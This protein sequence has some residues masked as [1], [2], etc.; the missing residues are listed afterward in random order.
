MLKKLFTKQLEQNGFPRPGE[1]AGMAKINLI[2][3]KKNYVSQ[4]ERL[5]SRCGKLFNINMYDEQCVDECNYHAKGI[6][7]FNNFTESLYRC[8]QNSMNSPGCSYANYHVTDNTQNN[9][10]KGYVTTMD[11]DPSY[12]YKKND[13]YALDCEMCYTTEGIE[14]TRITVVDINGDI[15]YDS[16][17]KPDNKIIDYNTV[18]SGITESMLSNVTCK[19]INVQAVLLSMIHSKSILVGHSLESDLK[20]LKII[21]SSVVDTSILFPHRMGPPKK[22]ALKTLCI[23]FLKLIIQES[24]HG[25]N[26]AEDAAVCIKLLKFY[27]RNRIA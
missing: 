25:H 12:V 3:A 6:G 13:I 23:E 22:R 24:E 4:Y 21:H 18:Y 8:C 19:L 7:R 16:L 1:R 2:R 5:C 9:I 27:L 14:L 10:L 26:S 20:A 11:K 17:V 15:A